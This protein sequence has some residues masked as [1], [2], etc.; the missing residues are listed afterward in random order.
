MRQYLTQYQMLMPGQFRHALDPKR[1]FAANRKVNRHFLQAQRKLFPITMAD[2]RSKPLINEFHKPTEFNQSCRIMAFPRNIQQ[3]FN[4]CWTKTRTSALNPGG[5]KPR[6]TLFKTLTNNSTEIMKV[7]I[8]YRILQ[9]K[10]TRIL[11][12]L[13]FNCMTY[14]VLT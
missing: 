6:I 3:K 8:I 10:I 14:F 9:N 5:A 2:K 1:M 12:Y 4:M 7:T 11:F 13:Y